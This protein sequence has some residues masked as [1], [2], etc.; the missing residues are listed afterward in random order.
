MLMNVDYKQMTVNNF[1]STPKAHT[2]V[3]VTQDTL[4]LIAEIVKVFYVIYL[5][6]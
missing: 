3:T 2:C 1:V 4:C 5:L 6:W